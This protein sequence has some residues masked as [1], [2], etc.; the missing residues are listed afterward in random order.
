MVT[1]SQDNLHLVHQSGIILLALSRDVR[2]GFVLTNICPS[3]GAV[4]IAAALQH[5]LA[6]LLSFQTGGGGATARA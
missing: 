1:I 4:G 2:L 6:D 3:R 5:F